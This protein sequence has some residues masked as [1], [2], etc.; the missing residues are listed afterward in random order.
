MLVKTDSSTDVLGLKEA[1]DHLPS[2]VIWAG[3]FH[4]R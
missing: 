2:K 3:N 4:Q 1:E